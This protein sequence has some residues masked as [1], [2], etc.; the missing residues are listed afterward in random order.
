ML[1]KILAPS[2]FV[3]ADALPASRLR[4]LTGALNAAKPKMSFDVVEAQQSDPDANTRHEKQHVMGKR[5]KP[6]LF[7]LRIARLRAS[8]GDRLRGPH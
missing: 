5:W 8:R 6:R 7:L 2:V 4:P 1:D 3:I